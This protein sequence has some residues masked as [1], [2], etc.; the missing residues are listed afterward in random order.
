MPTNVF[1]NMKSSPNSKYKKK[2]IYL[3]MFKMD[4]GIC[5]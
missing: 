2:N 1:A 3:N 4:M 5:I